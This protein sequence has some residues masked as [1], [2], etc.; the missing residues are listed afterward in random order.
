MA[1][2]GIDGGSLSIQP[3]EEVEGDSET[4][5]RDAEENEN[6]IAP[7]E[8]TDQVEISTEGREAAAEAR[9]TEPTDEGVNDNE[10]EAA[11]PT[12]LEAEISED[13]AVGEAN[14]GPETDDASS[15]EEFL[16]R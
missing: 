2:D 6:S 11:E 10:A 13:E 9:A 12:S 8:Q 4:V 1:I 16:G 3:T 5:R 7:A 15:P 14:E